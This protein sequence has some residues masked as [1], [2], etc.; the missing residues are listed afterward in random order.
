MGI[1]SITI[2]D[3]A[4]TDKQTNNTPI[5][6]KMGRRD[7]K[8]SNFEQINVIDL[9]HDDSGDWTHHKQ[10]YEL[11]GMPKVTREQLEKVNKWR[12]QDGDVIFIGNLDKTKE[13]NEIFENL[14]SIRLYDN[15]PNK[16]GLLY[17]S[18]L[19]MPKYYGP[20]TDDQGRILKNVGFAFVFTR[21]KDMADRMI[22]K[23]YI[24]IGDSKAEIRRFNQKRDES[25]YNT[26]RPS[27][28]NTPDQHK[29]APIHISPEQAPA[30]LQIGNWNGTNEMSFSS[31]SQASSPD[32]TLNEYDIT[33]S[34]YDHFYYY[35]TLLSKQQTNELV[36]FQ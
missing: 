33:K 34:Y 35:Y 22:A 32:Q 28:G 17:V 27:K 16:K 13:R 9:A 12:K 24:Q 29:T 30:S 15:R 23:K 4:H 5:I 20:E 36:Q 14:K 6:F 3:S 2:S 25:G 26:Q 19:D 21:T 31:S 10:S 8:K 1:H 18:K 7:N 11:D